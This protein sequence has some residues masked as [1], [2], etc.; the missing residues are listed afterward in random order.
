MTDLFP[1][2]GSTKFGYRRED[3]DTYFTQA[4]QAYEQPGAAADLAAVDVRRASF[5]LARGGYTTASVDSALDRLEVAFAARIKERFIKEQGHDAWMA[6]LAER[7]QTLYPRL[8]RPAG[9]RFAR[10]G[11]LTGG[12]SAADVDELLERLTAFFDQGKP[13]TADELRNATFK[14]RASWAAYEER[15]VDAYLARAVD[16]LLGAA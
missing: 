2:A 5:A 13:L 10:P 16:I 4:R 8:R 7:A 9:E 11:A 12:Y 6:Q 1:R 15:V 3:V 14:R